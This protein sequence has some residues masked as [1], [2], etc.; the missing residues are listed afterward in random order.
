MSRK[1]VNR[2]RSSKAHVWMKPEL[3]EKV[4]RKAEQRGLSRDGAFEEGMNKWV[5]EELNEQ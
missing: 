1:R 4:N 5:S 3:I 2:L